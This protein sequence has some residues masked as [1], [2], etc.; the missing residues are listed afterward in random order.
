VNTVQLEANESIVVSA[1]EPYKGPVAFDEFWHQRV[2]DQKGSLGLPVTTTAMPGEL[3]VYGFVLRGDKE[4]PAYT[5]LNFSDAGILKSSNTVFAGVPVGGADILPGD[6][7]TPEIAIANFSSRPAAAQVLYAVTSDSGTDG[8]VIKSVSVPRNS[9]VIQSNVA[10]G[11]LASNLTAVGGP[12]FR[13]VQLIG[14]D[15]Q[16]V[17]NGGSHPWTLESSATST[18]LLFNPTTSKYCVDV[19]IASG[20]VLWLHRYQLEGLE[21][22]AINIGTLIASG[23]KDD[24]G[25]IL[26]YTATSGELNWS[27]ESV[28]QAVGRLLVSNPSTSLARNFSC[29][30]Q[31]QAC[32]SSL[33]NSQLCIAQTSE[34]PMGPLYVTFWIGATACTG[35]TD[36][37]SQESS[38]WSSR[39]PSIASVAS[40]T[41]SHGPVTGNSGGTAAILSQMNISGCEVQSQG[42]ANVQVPTSLNGPTIAP[43]K[44]WSNQTLVNCN[45]GNVT[46]NFYGVSSCGSYTVLDQNGTQIQTVGLTFNEQLV[47]KDTNS[48]GTASPGSGAT[49]SSYQLVD[50]CASGQ[51]GSPLPS[52]AYTYILQTIT[53]A[54]TG[55]TV[56]INCIGNLAATV[57]VKDY[58]A[59]PNLACN[60]T[61]H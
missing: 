48:D 5:A 36:Y 29:G 38:T 11:S 18:L 8:R 39:S 21:T 22:K 49:N 58:T 25:N 23:Q 34:L 45:G 15:Q 28:G 7:F 26:P 13:T 30:S 35:P 33:Y 40:G 60:H 10:P 61:T 19:R 57:T 52:N 55:K 27:S 4:H 17:Q 1:C 37:T 51:V 43:F 20:G 47:A 44:T 16:Q 50:F 3:N 54:P 24:N 9:F 32:S 31:V 46:N 56:R 42:S 6:L 14:K 59:T 2:L 53:Y 41:L 12:T